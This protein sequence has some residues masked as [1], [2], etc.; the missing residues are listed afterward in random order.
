MPASEARIRANQIN[1]QKSTGPRTQEGKERSRRNSLKHGLTGEGIVLPSDDVAAV[2]RRFEALETE[3]APSNE[4]GLVLVQRIALLSVR[5]ERSARQESATLGEKVRNAVGEFDDRRLAEV[6][7]LIDW[8]ASEPAKNARRLRR[9][10]EGVDRLIKAWRDVAK[11]LDHPDLRHWGYG[12]WQ[13]IENLKGR[14]PEDFPTSREGALCKAIWGDGTLLETGEV[15]GLDDP[16]RRLWARERLHERIAAEI[17]ALRLEREDFDAEAL[18]LDRTGARD[19]VLFDPSKEATLARKYEAA[20]ERG[21]YRALKELRQVEA[22]TLEPPA[23]EP[24]PPDESAE[25]ELGSSFPEEVDGSPRTRRTPRRAD[26][27]SVGRPKDG[28]IPVETGRSGPA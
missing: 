22:G 6:E 7:K 26:I 20:T 9:T 16:A 3:L 23:P 19:R 15:D 2:T 11:D 10:P 13:R 25:D 8:I 24:G 17:E 14:R 4:M 28:P 1:A 18:E 5:L 27:P 12:Q 21:L